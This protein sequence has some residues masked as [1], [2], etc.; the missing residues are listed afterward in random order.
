[1]FSSVFLSKKRDWTH[2]ARVKGA[3]ATSVYISLHLFLPPKKFFW[4][5]Y[6]N[7]ECETYY[8]TY[9]P[10]ENRTNKTKNYFLATFVIFTLQSMALMSQERRR[11]VVQELFLLSLQLESQQLGRHPSKWMYFDLW[12]VFLCCTSRQ[13]ALEAVAVWTR[14]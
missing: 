4:P 6:S 1:M 7:T 9:R 3:G 8:W 11:K 2:D 10:S 12:S 5:L 13:V 14:A